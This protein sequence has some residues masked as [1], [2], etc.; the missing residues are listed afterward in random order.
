MTRHSVEAIV[1]SLER[2][3]IRYLIVGGLAVVAHG[4]VRFTADI[5]LVLAPDDDNLR[6]AVAALEGQ[7]Y[8]PRA[9]VPFEAF[10]DAAERAQWRRDKGMV[11]FSASSPEHPATQVNLFLEP[12]FEFDAAWQR[13]VRM[14]IAPL[15]HARFIA[16]SDLRAMKRVAGRPVDLLDLDALAR[17]HPEEQP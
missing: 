3:G 1:A 17:V 12:P 10:L 6:R 15:L 14:E 13:S 16:L 9:P 11:V 8:E 4:H 7:G 5:D 2:A